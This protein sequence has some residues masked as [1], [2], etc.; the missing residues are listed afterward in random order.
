MNDPTESGTL[1]D[2]APRG[3][4]DPDRVQAPPEPQNERLFL[5][6][7]TA[8]AYRAHFAFL[9]A[10][11]TDRQGRPTGAVH[12]FTATL[13]KL[14]REEKPHHIGVA[15][16]PPGPTF[17]HTMYADYKATRQKMDEDLVAQ[18]PVLRDVV[19][20]CNI[21]VLEV[22]GYEADDVLATVARR[23][24]A[25]GI[26][27]FIV[28]GDKDLCQVVGPLVKIY[29]ILKPGQD[30]L[31]L[32]EAGVEK[33][34]GVP[35][36]KITDVLALMG[37]ASDNVPGVPGIGEKTAVKLVQEFGGVEGVLAAAAAEPSPIKQPKLRDNLRSSVEVARLSHELVKV[38]YEVPVNA[39]F[40]SLQLGPRDER[41]L[42]DMFR[43]LNFTTLLAEV[44]TVAAASSSHE[45]KAVSTP[46]AL[47]ELVAKLA[48]ARLWALDTE[49]TGLDPLRADL[50]GISVAIDEATGWYVPLNL[51]PPMFAAEGA[52][53]N[54]DDRKRI[55]DTMRPVLEGES[56]RKC[57]QNAKYDLLVLRHAGV[58]VS[59]YAIDTMIASFCLD[60][61]AHQHNLDALALRHFGYRKIPTK[62][63]IGSGKTQRTMAEVPV[64]EVSEYACEDA[65]FTLRLA[66]KFEPRL[67][68]EHVG[69][70]FRD[71]EMPLVRVLADMEWEGV[72]VDV[73]L[74]DRMSKDLGE[75]AAA[76]ERVVCEVA[77]SAF[78]LNSPRQLGEVLFEKLKI[79]GAKRVKQT[80]TGW[81]T[82][83]GT[84][85]QFSD[86]EIVRKLLE[87]RQL[88]KLRGTYT[89]ALVRLVNPDTGRVHTSYSQTGA[90]TGRLA[91]SDPNLQNI[92][93]R[94]AEGR[95]IRRAFIPRADGW[96][97]VSADYSQIELRILAHLSGDADL[98][99][100]FAAG[101]DIHRN[102][103]A[104]VFGV[105]PAF[106]TPELRSRAKAINFGIVY[107]MGAVRLGQDTGLS[108]KEAQEFIDAYFRAYPA[109]RGWLDRTRDEAR[110][111]GEVST[112][113]GRRRSLREMYESQEMRVQ[114]QADNVAVNTP[115]QGSAADIIKVAMIAIHRDLRERG[116]AS[117]MILQVHDELVFDVAPGELD[118]MKTLIRERMEGAVSLRVPLHIEMGSGPDWLSAH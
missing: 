109:V 111:A 26:E 14:L 51:D 7:G 115:V 25:K 92:P 100:A 91:S 15:F 83:E 86:H 16:D 22:P 58:Q 118:A 27:T 45:Y 36:S 101:E 46:E 17:R 64:D 5:L 21:P 90:I 38:D 49:T 6:D 76:L 54:A 35:P 72:R 62:Q 88:T 4:A 77:G 28:T 81:S 65:D 68:D 113:L 89:E 110:V 29:N 116:F 19:R 9:R 32:D 94:T 37:D 2:D 74:L 75:R 107:G 43:E 55:L 13:F 84:L 63:L 117:K 57:G 70:L 105:A 30:T 114:A 47:R 103:A 82:D 97:I 52:T 85:S 8:L 71:V 95:E 87:Y 40:E 73:A 33:S 112:L 99:A 42:A 20:A 31:I 78:N 3:D 98:C 69:G 93:I 18:M 108:R 60:P 11:L 53:A 67:T 34:W 24:A 50:V 41:R 59:G 104:R 80:K 79:Q 44:S 1:F 23:A 102:T 12:G 106:V 61:E 48:A 66:R 39:D 10:N 56:H 96:T